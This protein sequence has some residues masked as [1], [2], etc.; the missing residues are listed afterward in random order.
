MEASSSESG[1][2]VDLQQTG[3]LC[4]GRLLDR[5]NLV[6]G[7]CVLRGTEDHVPSVEHGNIQG[8]EMYVC[9]NEGVRRVNS[10]QVLTRDCV[11]LS[12]LV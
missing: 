2:L 10:S 1:E 8:G 7:G 12:T 6:A 3:T 5:H 4:V 9:G 11:S